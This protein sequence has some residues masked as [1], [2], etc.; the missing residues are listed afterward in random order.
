MEE[1]NLKEVYSYFK[2][3]IL[4]ILIAIVVIIVIGNVY[5]II[6]REPMYRS[7]T[8]IVLV[9]ESKE[10]YSQSD[11]Q[12]NQNLIGTYSEIIKSRKVLSQVIENL[13]LKMS[14]EELSNNITTS[15][16]CSIISLTLSRSIKRPV[17]A[18]GLGKITPP[19]SL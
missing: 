17:G 1:I 5:T 13:K 7:N 11:S 8:T 4:W 2:S 15:L 16:L 3:K 18:L 6:T 19:F 14:V 9:G 12:L 10:G